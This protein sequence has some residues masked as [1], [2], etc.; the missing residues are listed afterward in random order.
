V[1]KKWGISIALIEY[2]KDMNAK[3]GG[4]KL[5]VYSSQ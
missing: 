4:L 2:G 1:I 3:K 5:R